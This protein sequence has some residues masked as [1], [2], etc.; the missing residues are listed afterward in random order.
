MRSDRRELS[1]NDYSKN[2]KDCK[3][4]KAK[5]ASR[6]SKSSESLFTNDFQ[7]FNSREREAIGVAV[8]EWTEGRNK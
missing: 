8:G 2:A 5:N 1:L 7:K 4:P 6:T 3:S